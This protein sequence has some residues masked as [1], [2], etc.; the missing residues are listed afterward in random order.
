MVTEWTEKHVQWTIKDVG[1][2]L[3][4]SI[5]TGLY[6]KLDVFRE[7]TQN[8]I[9]S[10][11]DFQRLTGR[12]P[13]D[14]VQVWVDHNSAALHIMDNGVGMDYADINKAKAIGVAPKLARTDDFVGFRGLGI[15]SGLAVCEKIVL[16]TTKVNVPVKYRLIIDCKD[17]VTEVEKPIP[18]DELL[19]GKFHIEEG[20]ANP[21]DH[22]THVKLVNVDDNRFG[23]LLDVGKLTRYAEQYLPV[24]FDPEWNKEYRE[25][26]EAALRGVPWTTVYNL[27]INND[28][29]Y[30]RFP[31][32]KDI[33]LPER[34]EIRDDDGRQVAVAWV[35]ETNRQGSTKVLDANSGLPRNFAVRIKNFAVGRRGLN[36]ERGTLYGQEVSDRDNLDWYVGEIYV[37][38]T[39]IRP[40]SNRRN[41]Q[42]SARHDAVVRAIRRFYNS[43]ALRARAWSLQVT[44]HGDCEAVDR[45]CSEAAAI[46]QS[47][48]KEQRTKEAQLQPILSSINDHKATLESRRDEANKVDGQGDAERTLIAREYLRK[49]EVKQEIDSAL[50][51]IASIYQEIGTIGIAPPEPAKAD[52]RSSSSRAR[53]K[54]L[55][56]SSVQPKEVLSSRVVAGMLPGLEMFAD[57]NNGNAAANVTG[58][59]KGTAQIIEV[60]VA[61]EAFGAAVAAI[62]GEE[63]EGYRRIM[64]RV[65]EELRR[66]G[67]HV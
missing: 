5:A 16:T 39:D 27:T 22:Y 43:T 57:G 28:P 26:V 58:S 44:N 40:D 42:P 17:I 13:E 65:N 34:H 32:E 41:L 49:P 10:Y 55:K 8:A 3:L 67:V 46:I 47:S 38:D 18:I 33:K 29:V 59:H 15:W 45:L 19:Q 30:R 54:R 7:Y 1:A 2:L 31:T 12:Q 21:N 56:G 61:V 23:E 6:Q 14:T 51:K 24:P 35:S 36:S 48:D 62:L 60:S 25:A 52:S 11:A 66:R 4:D 50:A 9:D 63:T 37:T 53:T 20:Q 64:G